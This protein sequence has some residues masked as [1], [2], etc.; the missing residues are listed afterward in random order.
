MQN[1]RLINAY[2]PDNPTKEFLVCDVDEGRLFLDPLQ[3]FSNFAHDPFKVNTEGL[4]AVGGEINPSTL[5]ASY[6]WGIFPWYAYKIYNEVLWYC[7]EQRFVIFPEKIHIGH[8]MKSLLNKNKFQIT[9]NQ[10]FEEVINNC[11]HVNHRDEHDCAWLNDSIE[12]SF[13]QLHKMGYAKSVEVWENGTLIGGFYG[14]FYKG[15]FEGDSMF[16][17]RPSASKIGLILLC[18]NP[19]IDG[20]K[21]KIIDTQFETPNFKHLGGEYISYQHYRDIMDE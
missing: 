3:M 7:P 20:V 9:I 8:S 2:P 6:K 17:L 4:F 1:I 10:A 19:Y 16:S 18:K 15:V 21:I 5:L 11:R 14:F 13:I 12:E